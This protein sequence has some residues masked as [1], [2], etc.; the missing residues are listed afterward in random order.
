MTILINFKRNLQKGNLDIKRNGFGEKINL[1]ECCAFPCFACRALP[2]PPPLAFIF[3]CC[4]NYEGV[5][6]LT[7]KS[8]DAAEKALE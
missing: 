8:R 1:K 7:S 5:V 6:F 3:I 2:P 4:K